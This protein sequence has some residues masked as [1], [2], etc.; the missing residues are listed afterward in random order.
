MKDADPS[1]FSTE[2]V[3]SKIVWYKED[4]SVSS[5]VPMR[6]GNRKAGRITTKNGR[7]IAQS[8]LPDGVEEDKDDPYGK[9]A[10]DVRYY[11]EN[12]HIL[13]LQGESAIEPPYHTII[14]DPAGTPLA[15]LYLGKKP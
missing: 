8:A 9:L 12:G 6:G 13:Y 11:H 10:N 1:D 4:G 14:Y 7:L 5:I 2:T 15:G 3:D